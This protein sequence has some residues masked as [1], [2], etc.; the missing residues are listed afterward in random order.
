MQSESIDNYDEDAVLQ[1]IPH[2]DIE[3]KDFID[4]F[5]N[6]NRVVDTLFTLEKK[7]EITASNGYMRRVY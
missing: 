7:G 1:M 4:K 6:P 5:E 2:K 3:A